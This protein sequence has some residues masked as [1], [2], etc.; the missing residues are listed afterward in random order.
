[1]TTKPA[2]TGPIDIVDLLFAQH[3][4]IRDLFAQVEATSGDERREAFDKLVR[5]LAVHET[6]EEEIVHP[7]AKRKLPGGEGIVE[8]RLHEEHEAKQVLKRLDQMDPNDAGFLETLNEL[9]IAVET[10]ARAEERYEFERLR[11]EFDDAQRR[12]LASA[13]K[14]AEAMAPT[15]PHPGAESAAKNMLAG[16]PLAVADRVR[17]MIRE[18]MGKDKRR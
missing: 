17:D 13:F 15:H 1:M 16:P 18:A 10:H 5:L 11:T 3:G 8:D 6:A 9:R 14:S 7:L 2:E 4:Q 12:A